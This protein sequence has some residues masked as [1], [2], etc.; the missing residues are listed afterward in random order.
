MEGASNDNDLELFR[1]DD[2]YQF[3]D[4]ALY[5]MRLSKSF[6]VIHGM[7]PSINNCL[8]VAALYGVFR[9][10]TIYVSWSALVF[11]AL[12]HYSD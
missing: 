12:L 4:L 1:I 11:L 6:V 10:K 2:L 5:S 8:Y 3:S 9:V 7:T